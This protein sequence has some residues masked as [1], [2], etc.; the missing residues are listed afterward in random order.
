M[1]SW[2]LL[3]GSAFLRPVDELTCR[4]CFV[5]FDGSKAIKCLAN[6]PSVEMN[7]D[8]IRKFAPN[9]AKGIDSLVTFVQA[10]S[11]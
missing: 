4:L 5:D 11:N 6:Q 7:E 1:L 2:Q 3:E 8:F 10:Y 9:V